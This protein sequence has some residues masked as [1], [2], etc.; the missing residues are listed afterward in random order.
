MPQ[1]TPSQARVVDPVLT[2]VARGYTNAELVGLSLFPAVPVGQRGGKI[3]QFGKEQFRLY[4]TGRAPGASVA[5]IQSA[6]SSDSYSLE[7]HAISEGVPFE[8]LDEASAVPGI[9]LGRSAVRRGQDIIALRL[10]KAQ[11]D[12][13]TTAAHY[14]ETNKVTLSGTAQWSNDSSDPIKD[15]EAG[16]D[17]VRSQVGRRPNTLVLGPPVFT[18]LKQHPK[19]VDRLKYTQREI[20]TPELLAALLGVSRVLVGD[21]VHVNASGAM[22]DVWGKVAVL[23]YTDLAGVEDAGRPS[24][25]Y[26]YRLANYPVVEAPYQDRDTRSWVYQIVDEVQP[27]LAGADAGYLISGAVA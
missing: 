9:N 4:N 3:I 24:F 12:L 8:L 7:N 2:E 27:V 23:A 1:M 5:R 10:E 22:V 26:T 21:A 25:G 17:A 20:A 13:A 11:A 6:Y 15:I 19:I 18:A 14:H 16:K